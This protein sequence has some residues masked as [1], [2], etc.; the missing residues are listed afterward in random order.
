MF[1]YLDREIV[2]ASIFGFITISLALVYCKHALRYIFGSVFF[3]IGLNLYVS[4]DIKSTIE[5]NIAQF[6]KGTI[7]ICRGVDSNRYRVSNKEWQ[8]E[9]D[10][11]IKDSLMIRADKCEVK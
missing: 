5:S 11:F 10:T 2:V 4:S 7:F 6:K 3:W 1:E 9:D 8:L